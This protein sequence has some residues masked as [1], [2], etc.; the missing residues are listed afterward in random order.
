MSSPQQTDEAPTSGL[1][2]VAPLKIDLGCGT[3]KKAGFIGVDV[4]A[5][6]G[7]DLVIDLTARW[8][9]ENDSVEEV[10][11][12]H[13]LEHLDA[14]E[15]IHFVNEL[16]RILKTGARATIIT[17]H[18]ASARAYGDLTHKWPPVSEFWYHYLLKS[19]RDTE[20]PHNDFYTCNFQTEFNYSL[21]RM[22]EGASASQRS[23]ALA[24]FKDAADDLWAMLVKLPAA[25]G[26]QSPTGR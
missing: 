18:W 6:P 9:W 22:H 26:D 13:F 20:A 10:H 5:F 17:P 25:A 2:Q 7:V 14:A 12:S 1:R 23:F 24:N 15:R 19:W 8:P 16:Y 3:R 21:S 11:C 4:R